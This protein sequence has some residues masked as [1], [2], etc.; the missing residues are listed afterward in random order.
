[1]RKVYGGGMR[2][3][4]I[5][6]AGGLFAMKNNVERLAIDHAHARQLESTLN[7]L[8]WVDSVLCVQTNIVVVILKVAAKRDEVIQLLAKQDI[9]IMAFGEGMLRLVTH[10]DVTSEEI[11]QTC[12]VLK[13]LSVI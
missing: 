7:E 4:G 2:Q 3:A 1:V 13:S 10:L 6:A 9:R 12:E 5:I 11:D 8:T